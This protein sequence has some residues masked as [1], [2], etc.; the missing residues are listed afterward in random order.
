MTDAVID[1]LGAMDSDLLDQLRCFFELRS[2]AGPVGYSMRA[3]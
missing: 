2:L 1:L 3:S